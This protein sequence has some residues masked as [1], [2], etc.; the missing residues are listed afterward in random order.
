MFAPV[1]VL[2]ADELHDAFDWYAALYAIG[3]DDVVR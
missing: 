1:D 3:H 2:D